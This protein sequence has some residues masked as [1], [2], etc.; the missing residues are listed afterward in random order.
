MSITILYEDTHLV[1]CLKPRG[2]LSQ[3]DSRG[4][5]AMPELLE[6]C[7]GGTIYPVHRLDGEVSGVMVYAKTKAA[8][9][10]LSQL[11]SD[12]DRFVKTYY[13]VVEGKPE[14]ADGIL[15]DL[16]F[17]DRFKNKTYVVDRMRGGVKA[18]KLSYETVATVEGGE[19]TLSLVRIRLYTGRSHQSRVQFASRGMSL[20]GDKRYGAKTAGDI[21]LFSHRLQF[22]HPMIRKNI[23]IRSVPPCDFVWSSFEDVLR[24]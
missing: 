23:D 11:V 19:V 10:K 6:E 20:A 16:L 21:A 3:T 2:V 22:A 9:A 15:E 7:C 5:P 1:V 14:P 17:H 12:H 24:Q 4:N 8:A 13:A 18:A